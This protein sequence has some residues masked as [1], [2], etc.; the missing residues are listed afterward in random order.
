[1]NFNAMSYALRSKDRIEKMVGN[2]RKQG[3]SEEKINKLVSVAVD[4][5]CKKVKEKYKE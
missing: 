2:A 4:E 3:V 1:M 5:M